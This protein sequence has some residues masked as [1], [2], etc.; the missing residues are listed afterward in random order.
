MTDNHK[1]PFYV[2]VVDHDQKIFNVFGLVDNEEEIREKTVKLQDEGRDVK[3]FYSI[4]NPELVIEKYT[5]MF[6]YTLVDEKIVQI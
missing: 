1:G 6:G 4:N 3:A 5:N 2:F